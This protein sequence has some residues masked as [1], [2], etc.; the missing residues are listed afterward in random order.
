[1]SSLTSVWFFVNAFVSANIAQG[2]LRPHLSD[3]GVLVTDSWVWGY[4]M[5]I[6]LIP[7]VCAPIIGTLAWAQ[8]RVRPLS[9]RARPRARA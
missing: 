9:T 4:A 3:E 2:I 1:M 5:F 7:V 6:I 8:R